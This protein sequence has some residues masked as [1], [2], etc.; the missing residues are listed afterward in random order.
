M[1]NT[2]LLCINNIR[3]HIQLYQYIHIQFNDPCSVRLDMSN[4]G[5]TTKA[6]T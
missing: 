5:S 4:G 6:E 3:T 1:L 2:V